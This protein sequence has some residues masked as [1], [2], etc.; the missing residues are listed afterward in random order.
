MLYTALGQV[1][2][3]QDCYFNARNYI[4]RV[5]KHKPFIFF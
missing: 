1:A 2:V 5:S 3:L 4:H